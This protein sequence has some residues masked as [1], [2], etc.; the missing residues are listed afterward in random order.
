MKKITLF[1]TLW[2]FLSSN[3]QENEILNNSRFRFSY[4]TG[5]INHFFDGEPLVKFKQ[6]YDSQIDPRPINRILQSSMGCQFEF[7]I[8]NKSS[9]YFELNHF[10]YRHNAYS[11]NQLLYE[12]ELPLSGMNERQFF[13]VQIGY[14]Q[15]QNIDEKLDLFWGLGFT[16]RQLNNEYAKG[17]YN[18]FI[19][20]TRVSISRQKGNSFGIH[21]RYGIAYNPIPKITLTSAVELNT[22]AFVPNNRGL[23][24]SRLDLSLRLGVGYNF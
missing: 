16:Y 19:D 10:Y 24:N 23:I 1:L 5:I 12:N 7:K 9:L 13:G 2:G 11:N 22:F 3:A 6:T 18:V 4:Y 8:A 17:N 14:N 21:A 15:Y 20:Q